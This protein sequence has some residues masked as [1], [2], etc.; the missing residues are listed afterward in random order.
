MENR[1]M[2]KDSCVMSKLL[3]F[4]KLWKS[5]LKQ[6]GFTVTASG[7]PPR[8]NPPDVTPAREDLCNCVQKKHAHAT[9]HVHL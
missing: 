7:S 8:C 4:Q 6:N 1:W 3:H 5:E 2:D 9:V